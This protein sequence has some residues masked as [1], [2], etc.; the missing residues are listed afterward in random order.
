[1][2]DAMP[3]ATSRRSDAFRPLQATDAVVELPL[4]EGRT[5]IR[6]RCARNGCTWVMDRLRIFAH[7][8]SAVH[9]DD[10]QCLGLDDRVD[11]S[12]EAGRA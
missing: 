5:A 9:P 11:E 6:L 10:V 2:R 7:R 1:M 8:R 4:F 12:K 3:F